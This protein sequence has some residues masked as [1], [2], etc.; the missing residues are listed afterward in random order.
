MKIGYSVKHQISDIFAEGRLT[1]KKGTIDDW[2][3]YLNEKDM[4]HFLKFPQISILGH[5]QVPMRDLFNVHHWFGLRKPKAPSCAVVNCMVKIFTP[6]LG[7]PTPPLV[8]WWKHVAHSDKYGFKLYRA[9]VHIQVW[10]KLHES[11]DCTCFHSAIFS[12]M[13]P[14]WWYGSC[15]HNMI[16]DPWYI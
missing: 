11:L 9:D 10:R 14:L 7:P 6:R 15:V 13:E 12:M 5:Q 8:Y 4:Q 1:W 2:R 16:W 3:E